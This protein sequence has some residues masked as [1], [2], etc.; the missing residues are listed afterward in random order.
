M[1]NQK[2]IKNP[3][4]RASKMPPEIFRL[5]LWMFSLNR[6]AEH[7]AIHLGIKPRSVYAVFDRLR[8]RMADDAKFLEDVTI[9]PYTIPP[10]VHC[11]W[12]DLFK[13]LHECPGAIDGK[14]ITTKTIPHEENFGSESVAWTVKYHVMT[15]VGA[16]SKC[17]IT[18]MSHDEAIQRLWIFKA[19]IAAYGGI[20][21][22]KLRLY[23][24]HF[25]IVKNIENNPALQLRVVGKIG[26]SSVATIIYGA[27][28]RKLTRDPL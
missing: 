25:L 28:L 15:K 6:S 21:E 11:F 3:L 9:K 13:C 24:T 4:Y 8:N 5:L 27:L 17:Y 22:H 2:K 10:A 23:F 26:T 1:V 18:K 12:G 7:V 20:P 16:C 19:W 14:Q